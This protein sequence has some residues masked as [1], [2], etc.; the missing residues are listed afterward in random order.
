MRAKRVDSRVKRSHRTHQSLDT[1]RTRC[2]VCI[3]K[4]TGPGDGKAPLCKHSLG[5]VEERKAF[6]RLKVEGF[7]AC[8]FE[9]RSGWDRSL[10]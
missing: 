9:N 6:L 4:T 8:G 7:D 1:E 5:A 10:L 3:H 2:I